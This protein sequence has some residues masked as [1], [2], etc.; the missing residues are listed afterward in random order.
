MVYVD[1]VVNLGLIVEIRAYATAL[2]KAIEVDE[3]QFLG[4]GRGLLALEKAC[5]RTD[6]CGGRYS[7]LD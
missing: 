5:P 6:D 4:Q 3:F 1:V 7:P 2:D